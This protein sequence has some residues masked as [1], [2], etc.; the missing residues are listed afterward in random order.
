MVPGCMEYTHADLLSPYLQSPKF[1]L[2]RFK[3]CR[4][5]KVRKIVLLYVQRQWTSLSR[6]YLQS[7]GNFVHIDRKFLSGPGG[8]SAE[9]RHS[10]FAAGA[11]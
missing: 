8:T 6:K 4:F 1:Q 9:F 7:G 3:R 11:V 2:R 5:E 10:Q